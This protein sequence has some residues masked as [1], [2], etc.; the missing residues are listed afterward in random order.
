MRLLLLGG[1]GMDLETDAGEP[2]PAGAWK[3]LAYLALHGPAPRATVAGTLW[4]DTTEARAKSCLRS[5][6]WRLKK[7]VPG[8]VEILP[9]KLALAPGVSTDVGELV[10]VA[11]AV[12]ESDSGVPEDFSVLLGAADLVPAW[13]DEW[14]SLERERLRL[15]RLEA[16]DVLAG[17]L[18]A[19][20]RPGS[21]LQAALAAVQTDP[22]RE[23]SS[24]QAIQALLAQGN[25]A[26]AQARYDA[27]AT[28]LDDELGLAPSPSIRRL[29]P[30]AH[31]GRDTHDAHETH[32]TRVGR[33]TR[34]LPHPAGAHSRNRLE[35]IGGSL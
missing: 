20:G 28:L 4:P 24:R 27:Y 29:A 16:L 32:D 7:T 15:L 2:A 31:S 11:R 18:I 25:V 33:R 35:P 19:E 1:F 21:A 13:D 8:A 10:A 6:L 17:R 23:S 34:A 26:Q 14:L 12:L 9:W 22:L 5:A 30:A 3:L